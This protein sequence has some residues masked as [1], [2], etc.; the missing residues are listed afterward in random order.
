LLIQ[1]VFNP[2]ILALYLTG[3]GELI[4]FLRQTLAILFDYTTNT[5]PPKMGG[6]IAR[7]LIMLKFLC[8]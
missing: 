4:V 7:P 3:N 5:D 1:G 2:T 6:V 8:R